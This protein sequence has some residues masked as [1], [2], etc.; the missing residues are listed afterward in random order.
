MQQTVLLT[1]KDSLSVKVT[2]LLLNHFTMNILV[3]STIQFLVEYFLYLSGK[4]FSMSLKALTTCTQCTRYKN[5][6]KPLIEIY[7][8]A[9]LVDLLLSTQP[10]RELDLSI[11]MS[12]TVTLHQRKGS[13]VSFTTTT[14]T[15]ISQFFSLIF[16]TESTVS[17]TNTYFTM[18]HLL[19]VL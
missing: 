8:A 15:I 1:A 17:P 9:N 6:K 7:L 14:A 16:I 5:Y 12:V 2:I 10:P 13:V 19:K 3:L 4:N 11:L 18:K